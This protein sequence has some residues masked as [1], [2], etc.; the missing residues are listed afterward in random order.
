MAAQLGIPR[1]IAAQM[2]ITPADMQKNSEA[3]DV[4]FEEVPQE[5][6]P[7]QQE[8]H[9]RYERNGEIVR[10]HELAAMTEKERE[11][12]KAEVRARISDEAKARY[13]AAQPEMEIPPEIADLI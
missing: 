4:E 2:L 7:E 9:D 10:R 12:S 11:A 6:T 3:I 1:E 5:R 13:A 8:R